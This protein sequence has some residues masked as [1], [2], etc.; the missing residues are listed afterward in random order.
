M[1]YHGCAGSEN[2]GKSPASPR[3]SF[4]G[5]STLRRAN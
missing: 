1:S 4:N 2:D 5:D 3:G